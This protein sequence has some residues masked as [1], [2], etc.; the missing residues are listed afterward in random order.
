MDFFSFN[1][2]SNDLLSANDKK[3]TIVFIVFNVVF[4]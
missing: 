2:I 3:S 4:L 1:Y